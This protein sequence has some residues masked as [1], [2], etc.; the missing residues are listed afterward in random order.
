[1]E[2][3]LHDITYRYLNNYFSYHDD[4][5]WNFQEDYY[6][7]GYRRLR[8]KKDNKHKLYYVH[9]IIYWLHNPDWDLHNPKLLI[10]HID[11]NT[12]N[13]DISNL[14]SVTKQENSFNTNAKGYTWDKR[15]KKYRARI[16]VNEKH[17]SLGYFDKKEDA[18]QAY[19]TAKAIYHLIDGEV[20]NAHRG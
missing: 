6:D 14:R 3:E 15:D 20:A 19:L 11:G 17:I 13:N 9:R 18:R 10:D 5:G 8:L 7:H 2:F 12:Q 16:K 4:N 1:M